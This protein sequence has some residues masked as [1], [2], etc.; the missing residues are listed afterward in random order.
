MLFLISVYYFIYE[1]NEKILLSLSSRFPQPITVQSVPSGNC[2]VLGGKQTGTSCSWKVTFEA[3]CYKM[4]Q[5]NSEK[6]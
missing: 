5:N 6:Y 4:K 2:L 3:N 1:G